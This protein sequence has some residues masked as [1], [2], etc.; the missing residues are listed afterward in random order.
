MLQTRCCNY[1]PPQGLA[2]KE[3]NSLNNDLCGGW[4]YES[5]EDGDMCIWVEHH[6]QAALGFAMQNILNRPE[7]R[8]KLSDGSEK[9][10][11]E[12]YSN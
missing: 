10:V 6:E 8:Q 12:R 2:A 1:S 11:R 3:V 4:L 9:T 5:I 7:L